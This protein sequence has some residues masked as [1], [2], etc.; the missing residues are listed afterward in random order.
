MF[1]YLII[2]NKPNLYGKQR[3]WGAI[4]WGIF[5]IFAGW[6]LDIFSSSDVNK[7]YLPI[8]FLCLLVLLC[9]FFVASK[10]GVII[11]LTKFKTLTIDIIYFIKYFI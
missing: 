5:S 10:L 8:Y 6:L 11:S 3:C 7:N 1:M 9:N 2:G 4:G